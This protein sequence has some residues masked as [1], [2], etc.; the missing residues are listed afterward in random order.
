MSP[1]PRVRGAMEVC[2]CFWCKRERVREAEAEE[3]REREPVSAEVQRERGESYY[4]YCL[5]LLLLFIIERC[6]RKWRDDF[7][8][9]SL[10]E[11]F[12]HIPQAQSMREPTSTGST[13]LHHPRVES[14]ERGLERRRER[15]RGLRERECSI[16]IVRHMPPPP[17]CPHVYAFIC[18]AIIAITWTCSRQRGRGL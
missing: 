7:E 8:R 4:Y 17:P 5:L 14:C 6:E 10:C 12:R 18:Q 3:R 1:L 2:R 15:E 16:C 13:F 9:E 11:S